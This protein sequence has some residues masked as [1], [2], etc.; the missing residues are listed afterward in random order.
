MN[1]E[2]KWNRLNR[3]PQKISGNNNLRDVLLCNS[4]MIREL[5]E[6]SQ[7]PPA[8]RAVEGKIIDTGA[9]RKIYPR[10]R[11]TSPRTV[12]V[13]LALVARVRALACNTRRRTPV[14]AK[15][16]VFLSFF[17]DSIYCSFYFWSF[18]PSISLSLSLS[19]VLPRWKWLFSHVS[20]KILS[21]CV[22]LLSGHFPLPFSPCV[23]L[24]FTLGFRN[25]PRTRLHHVSFFYF[26]LFSFFFLLSKPFYR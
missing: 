18:F 20:R 11:A 17:F 24:D 12:R 14:D 7:R 13:W 9:R 22:F 16:Q 19:L 3:A 21:L 4:L 15:F 25:P 5:C 8:S 10:P 23:K 6:R 26:F 1:L 2:S